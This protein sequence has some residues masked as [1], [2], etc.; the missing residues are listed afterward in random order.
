MS[1]FTNPRQRARGVDGYDTAHPEAIVTVSHLR[2]LYGSGVGGQ[3][4]SSSVNAGEI[5]G[6]IGPNGAG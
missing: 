4:V 3:D 2:K 6:V 5:F 1:A